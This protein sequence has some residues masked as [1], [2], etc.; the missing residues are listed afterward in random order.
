MVVEEATPTGNASGV[1]GTWINRNQERFVSWFIDVLVYVVILNL[2]V[3]YVSTVVIDSF[4][5]SVFTAVVLKLL[6]DAITGLEHR[7]SAWFEQ[8]EGTI[9]R[10]LRVVAIFAILFFS[11]FV[12]LRSSISSSATRWN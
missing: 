11:T 10:V 2:F 8:H 1:A 9:W 7:V 12:V 3:E 5:I 4:T 6:I